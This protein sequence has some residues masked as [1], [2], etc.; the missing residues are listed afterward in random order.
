MRNASQWLAANKIIMSSDSS[1][2]FCL[3]FIREKGSWWLTYAR[4]YNYS[5]STLYTQERHFWMRNVSFEWEFIEVSEGLSKDSLH[6]S[7]Y[8][9]KFYIFITRSKATANFI[10]G[11]CKTIFPVY[12]SFKEIQFCGNQE[13]STT[14]NMMLFSSGGSP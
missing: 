8:I 4:N 13:D 2:T 5:L 9:F 6:I 1:S 14:I 11:S 3:Y 10:L 7:L 12:R